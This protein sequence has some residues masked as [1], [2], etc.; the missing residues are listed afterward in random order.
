MSNEITVREALKL[1]GYSR[2]QIYNL[3]V[4]DRI[5]ARKEGHEYRVDRRSLL[6]YVDSKDK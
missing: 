3:I 5:K 4:A 2:Q 6:D 1:T